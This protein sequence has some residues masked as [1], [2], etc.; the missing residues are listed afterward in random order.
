MMKIPVLVADDHGV[1]RNGLKK[2]L[3]DTPDLACAGEAWDGPSLVAR[4]GER[5][6]GLLILDLSMPGR[7]GLE[8][9]KRVKELRPRLPVLVF[10]MHQEEQYAVRALQA[11]ARGYL[12]KDCD[13]ELLLA[14]IRKVACGGIHV[15]DKVAGLLARNVLQP[16]QAPPHTMLSDREYEVFTRLVRGMSPTHIAEE[17]SLSIKTVSTHKAHLLEKMGLANQS[18][19]IRYALRHGLMDAIPEES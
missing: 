19:L 10:T 11:G 5:D 16:D 4:L 17:F 8:L 14:A 6:W 13:G 3:D 2:I 15:S 1:I 7:N 18:E 12:T 9:I